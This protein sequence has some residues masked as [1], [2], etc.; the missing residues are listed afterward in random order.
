MTYGGIFSF[1]LSQDLQRE[2]DKL[3]NKKV[4]KIPRFIILD[5]E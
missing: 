1:A 3:L 4:K 2:S 5:D